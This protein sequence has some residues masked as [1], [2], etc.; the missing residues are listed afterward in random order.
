MAS[1]VALADCDWL[2]RERK[3]RCDGRRPICVACEKRGD[4]QHCYF[5]AFR[6]RRLNS[7]A[8]DLRGPGSNDDVPQTPGE[9]APSLRDSTVVHSAPTNTATPPWSEAQS[10]GLATLAGSRD[11][12]LYGPSSTV[13]FLRHVIHNGSRS[14]PRTP[15]QRPSLSQGNGDDGARVGNMYAELD[16]V[17]VLPARRHAN[18]FV[19]CYWE[20]IHPTFPILHRPTFMK[21]FELCF[22]DSVNSPMDDPIFNATLNLVCALGSKFSE[23]VP[24][25]QR[26]AVADDFYQKSRKADRMSVMDS[27]SESMVQLLLLSGVYLQSTQHANRCWNVVGLAIR[28]AQSIGLHRE[29]AG[30]RAESQL[31]REMRRRIWHVCVSLDR[32]VPLS[33]R[34]ICCTD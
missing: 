16:S 17:P 8:V 3:T 33:S 11:A 22:H 30:A 27:T 1:D 7:T 32:L 23:L 10:D 6:R 14:Q 24:P 25:Q 34:H 28:L 21:D 13:A 18:D 4:A 15:S 19:R 31:V 20:F 26:N 5:V 12:A 9:Q 29:Q 2:G